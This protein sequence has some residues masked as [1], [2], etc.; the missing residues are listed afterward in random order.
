[1]ILVYILL[2]MFFVVAFGVAFSWLA[3]AFAD[4]FDKRKGKNK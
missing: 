1:M 2:A 3:M 4:C